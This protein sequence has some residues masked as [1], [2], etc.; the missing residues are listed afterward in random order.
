ML[1]RVFIVVLLFLI[2]CA[3]ILASVLTS[4][5]ATACVLKFILQ[6][7]LRSAV[8]DELTIGAQKL[9]FSELLSFSDVKVMITV[10]GQQYQFHAPELQVENAG[11]VLLKPGELR[12]YGKNVSLD[13]AGLRI[14]SAEINAKVLV[15][16]K[17]KNIL[18]GT[19]TIPAMEAY[20]YKLQKLSTNFEGGSYGISF[21]NFRTDFYNGQIIGK[22]D[23]NWRDGLHY[24]TN[25]QFEGID[26]SALREVD[27]S[28]YKQIEGVVQGT[29]VI[30]GSVHS[31]D[32]LRLKAQITKGG[33]INA[34]LFKQIM[35][36]LS[37]LANAAELKSDVENG[38]KVPAEVV[39]VNLRNVDDRKISGPVH[40]SVRKFNLDLNT[41]LDILCDGSWFSLIE[42]YRNL[43]K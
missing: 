27:D 11:E 24:R 5:K 22:I 3:G 30:G 39:T 12:I 20:R 14:P 17:K 26:I 1:K 7:N 31:F 33:R 35:P 40:L 10:S 28:I 8:V 23:V 36:Q 42:A 13:N 34:S 6:K 32:T 9:S 18:D 19:L 15:R 16:T 4:P 2:V 43:G 41:S 37:L 29:V 38:L 21:T 25:L